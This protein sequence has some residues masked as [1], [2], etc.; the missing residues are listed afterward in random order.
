[1]NDRVTV[2]F[3]RDA[4]EPSGPRPRLP[5]F[6]GAEPR[7]LTVAAAPWRW[8]L[9]ARGGAGHR[10]RPPARAGA[11]LRSLAAASGPTSY[12]ARLQSARGKRAGIARARRSRSPRAG[13]SIERSPTRRTCASRAPSI[14]RSRS[15]STT[16]PGRTRP[17]S[18]RSSARESVPGDVLPG[19]RAAALLPRR[20]DA[21]SCRRGYPIGD[22]TWGHAPM[23]K[24][25]A[26]RAAVAADPRDLGHGQLRGPVPAHVP[27]AVRAL[28]RDHAED[29]AQL[30]DADGAV[31]GRHRRLP[32][33]RASTRSSTRRSPVRGRAR[34]SSC[35]TPAASARRRS[36]RCR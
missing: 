17:R 24:L 10:G 35:T 5:R 26:G 23:S 14:G 25:T 6:R 27:A 19:R 30:Q 8:R 22:H 12:F 34:S 7:H 3:D 33:S 4:T 29:P 31:D 18:S 1:M 11:A 15:R 36:P 2:I 9:L 21:R 16:A 32:A 28:E 13:R 20:D